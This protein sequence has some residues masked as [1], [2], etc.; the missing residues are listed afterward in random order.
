MS[1]LICAWRHIHMS[2]D[3]WGKHEDAGETGVAGH[4]STHRFGAALGFGVEAAPTDHLRF[5]FDA[6]A[7]ALS[8]PGTNLG[9]QG[10]LTVGF[11]F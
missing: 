2:P 1:W 9:L 3:I 10:V 8:G 7:L 5:G 6:E 4:E 11:A